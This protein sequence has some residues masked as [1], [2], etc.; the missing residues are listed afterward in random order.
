VANKH[1]KVK[2]Q[3]RSFR[4][5][6]A[7]CLVCRHNT[8]SLEDLRVANMARN[9]QVAKSISDAGWAQFRTTLE[10]KAVCAGKQVVAVKPASSS[11]DLFS[12]RRAGAQES[13]GAHSQVSLPAVSW[14]TAITTPR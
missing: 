3:R 10:Y 4:P 1:Q 8:I 11:Q 9:Q 7:L 13:L 14:R 2:R 5:K 12:L 6:R